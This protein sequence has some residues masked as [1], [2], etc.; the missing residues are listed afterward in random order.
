[1]LSAQVGIGTTTPNASAALDITSTKS[2]LLIPRMTLAQ[3]NA[4]ASPAN[5]LLIY[6]TNNTPGFY[7][8]NGSSWQPFT[9]DTKWLQTGNNIYNANTGNV[10]VGTSSPTS[11][12][13]VQGA[14][15]VSM[16]LNTGFENQSLSPFTTDGDQPWQ[17]TNNPPEVYAGSF[18]ARSNPNQTDN[19]MGHLRFTANMTTAG[20]ISF[21]LR[22]STEVGSNNWDYLAFFINDVEQ[23][24]WAQETPWQIVSFSVPAGNNNFRWT[25]RKDGSRSMGDDRV[26]IDNVLLR[27]G[28]PAIRIVDGAQSSGYV[29]TSDSNGYASWAPPA[30]SGGGSGDSKWTQSGNNIYNNNSGNVG[31]G[32]TNPVHKLHVKADAGGSAALLVD[33]NNAVAARTYGI[34]GR[35]YSGDELGSAGI[36]GESVTSGSFEIGVKGDYSLWGAAVAG[37]GWATSE[38]DMPRTGGTSGPNNDMGIYGG[39]NFSTG[40]GVYGLNKNTGGSAFAGYF[41]GNHAITGTKSASVPTTEG[42]QLLYSVESPEI[43]FEDFGRSVL[44]NGEAHIRFDDMFIQTIFVD[45]SHPFHVFLQEQGDSNG[46]YFIPD[47]DGKGFRVKEKK[48]GNSNIAFSYRVTAKRRF[49]QDHRFGVDPIQP[50]ENNLAKAKNAVLPPKDLA[51]A[52]KMVIEAEQEKMAQFAIEERER[53]QKRKAQEMQQ[54]A[55]QQTIKSINETAPAKTGVK[56]VNEFKM[57]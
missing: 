6:Q 51:A 42:N 35:T 38:T 48:G 4:I 10:G 25:Y 9:G 15:N 3:R 32:V 17:I 44:R 20:T 46:L 41:K 43:W 29:L 1:M 16:P 37:I 24:R 13:H 22:T 49:Y 27:A 11:K 5:G 2:G 50:L 21:A 14:G 26:A 54:Q 8:Y 47:A 12:L 31:I 36:F 57:N 53:E 33:N 30:S 55:Q 39:V 7:Y 45:D 18:A 23:G 28:D 34:H 19:Q 52:R 56:N 40:I